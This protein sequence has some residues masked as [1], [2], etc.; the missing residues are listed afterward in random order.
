M[1]DPQ[2]PEGAVVNGEIHTTSYFDEQGRLKYVV[3]I[4]GDLNIAQALG[5]LV[6]TGI[7]LF[8]TYNDNAEYGPDE[9]E[10]EDDD[11]TDQL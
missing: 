2:V 11:D 6:L 5:L 3:G 4:N 9:E 8:K 1:L 10:T 7:T